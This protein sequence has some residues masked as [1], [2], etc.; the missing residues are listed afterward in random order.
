MFPI[1]SCE[2]H[3]YFAETVHCFRETCRPKPPD[4]KVAGLCFCIYVLSLFNMTDS[5]A[6]MGQFRQKHEVANEM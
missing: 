3:E 1:A 4:L 6:Q 2:D 5:A